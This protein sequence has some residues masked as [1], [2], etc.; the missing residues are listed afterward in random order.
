MKDPE[1]PTSLPLSTTFLYF[2][3]LWW[4]GE[5][6]DVAQRKKGADIHADRQ[7]DSLKEAAKKINLMAV[8]L[9]QCL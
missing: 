5:R 6:K 8:S 2:P 4:M 3:Q 7:T 9:R 1:L